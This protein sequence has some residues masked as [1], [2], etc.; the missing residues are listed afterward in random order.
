MQTLIQHTSIL[1][2][3]IFSHIYYLIIISVNL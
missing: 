2:P 1:I 3:H